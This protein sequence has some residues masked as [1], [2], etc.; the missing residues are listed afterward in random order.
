[1][2]SS[3]WRESY[4]HSTISGSQDNFFMIYISPHLLCEALG[5]PS[6]RDNET[7]L[8]HSYP[9]FPYMKFLK[10]SLSVFKTTIKFDVQPW[11]SAW[12]IEYKWI[13]DICF[14]RIHYCRV[15]ICQNMESLYWKWVY[16]F[17]IVIRNKHTLCSYSVCINIVLISLINTSYAHTV[18]ASILY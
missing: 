15:W 1:M 5:L 16:Q 6:V 17:C 10:L 7:F 4:S 2:I 14:H 8:L 9:K 18:N 13:Q 12:C 3:N 11:M